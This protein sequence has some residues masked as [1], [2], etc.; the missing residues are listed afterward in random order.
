MSRYYVELRFRF[1]F[2]RHKLRP[3]LKVCLFQQELIRSSMHMHM[4]AFA[5]VNYRTAYILHIISDAISC[6]EVKYSMVVICIDAHYAQHCSQRSVVGLSGLSDQ[7]TK[8][9]LLH[10]GQTEFTNLCR[11]SDQCWKSRLAVVCSEGLLVFVQCRCKGLQHL[12]LPPRH[13]YKSISAWHASSLA[14]RQK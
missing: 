3:D 13:S 14:Q 1:Y 2:H 6:S 12:S 4:S 5:A 9:L 8:V 7:V 10:A 11:T